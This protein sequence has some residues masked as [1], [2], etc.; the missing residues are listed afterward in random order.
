VSAEHDVPDT[1]QA[2]GLDGD[3]VEAGVGRDS[4]LLAPMSSDAVLFDFWT[5]IQQLDQ[6]PQTVSGT[7][8][9]RGKP[10]CEPVLDALGATTAWIGQEVTAEEASRGNGR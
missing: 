7:D 5:V 9:S 8:S 2:S 1:Q 10:Y 3:Q 6:V 4:E